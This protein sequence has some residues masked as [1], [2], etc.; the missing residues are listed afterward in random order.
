[1]P[2]HSSILPA[3]NVRLLAASEVVTS[4]EQED[5]GQTWKIEANV[6]GRYSD[7]VLADIAK[8]PALKNAAQQ[9]M[10]RI[11]SQYLYAS[12]E[13]PKF[14]KIISSPNFGP[15]SKL[16]VDADYVFPTED[17]PGYFE[18]Q[19]MSFMETVTPRSGVASTLSL[20]TPRRRHIAFKDSTSTLS[21]RRS[22]A[23]PAMPNVYGSDTVG[24]HSS[25]V[26]FLTL[27]S[28]SSWIQWT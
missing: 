8:I 2:Y 12:V 18:V 17:S 26:T 11:T 27:M 22:I 28:T 3:Q 21:K 5:N 9:K 10:I 14:G 24:A 4:P 23:R 15:G 13:H 16:Y 19:D 20:S 25:S 1:M 7:P 6:V